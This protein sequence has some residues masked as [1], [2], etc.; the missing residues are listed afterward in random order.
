MKAAAA[1]SALVFFAGGGCKHGA[2]Q[3]RQETASGL[4]SAGSYVSGFEP[5]TASEFQGLL[6]SAG[7]EFL[8]C[9]C[10]NEQ[11]QWLAYRFLSHQ[12][13]GYVM[14]LSGVSHET[15]KACAEERE[16]TMQSC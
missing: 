8:G 16:R 14:P 13:K 11:G 10:V 3:P 12:A 7:A 4:A 5:V 9:L 1:A 2:Q 6:Y 15:A